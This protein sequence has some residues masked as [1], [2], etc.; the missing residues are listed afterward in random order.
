MATML[1]ATAS[2]AQTLGGTQW[3][4]KLESATTAG[5]IV[6][7]VNGNTIWEFTQVG[8]KIWYVNVNDVENYYNF[9]V[10]FNAYTNTDYFIVDPSISYQLTEK[11]GTRRYRL[12]IIYNPHEVNTVYEDVLTLKIIDHRRNVTIASTSIKLKGDAVSS[13]KSSSGTTNIN[14]AE[15]TEEAKKN[16]KFY[17]DGKLIIVKGDQ[18]FNALG[19]QTK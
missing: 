10:N 11:P 9:D 3:F 4:N 16:G 13:I 14:N 2:M 19:A 15:T 12:K 8:D 5:P 7:S 6:D 17:K 18:E 1:L